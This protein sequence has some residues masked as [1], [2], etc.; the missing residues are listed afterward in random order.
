MLK[1]SQTFLMNKL[2]GEGDPTGRAEQHADDVKSAGVVRSAGDFLKAASLGMSA[3]G[4]MGPFKAAATLAAGK[5][6]G[7][8]F[9]IPNA[10]QEEGWNEAF[11]RAIKSGLSPNAAAMQAAD[12]VGFLKDTNDSSPEGPASPGTGTGTVSGSSALGGSQVF[13]DARDGGGPSGAPSKG[14]SPGGPV[15]GSSAKGGS[16]HFSD[17]RDGNGTGGRQKDPGKSAGKTNSHESGA[18][19]RGF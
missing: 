14:N 6:V 17:A 5:G 11:D 9:D 16:M 13:S 4:P 15:S 2:G 10:N 18:G 8:D 3:M 12:D 7:M 1:R 19:R